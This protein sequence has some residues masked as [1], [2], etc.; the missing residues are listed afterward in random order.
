MKPLI[1]GA[2]FGAALAVVG[3]AWVMPKLMVKEKASPMGYEETIAHI[4]NNVTNAGWKV[5]AL[6]RLDKTLAKEG[7]TVLPVASF[8][9]CQPD[10]AEQVLLDD[11]ARSLSV[12][13]PCS[14][15]VY[16]KAD[17]KTYIST[18][19]AAL[20]GRM[21]G[22]TAQKVMGGPVARETASFI[23]FN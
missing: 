19:N 2:V 14:I 20:M 4:Q 16:E 15:A 5:S 23:E 10:H 13:M 11:K 9:I 6:M 8:K 21:F 1:S 18:M 7:K 3:S 17:G 22:G 12:M